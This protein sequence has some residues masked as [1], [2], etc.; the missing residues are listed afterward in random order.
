MRDDACHR[1]RRMSCEKGCESIYMHRY[2]LINDVF[3]AGIALDR[4]IRATDSC[5]TLHSSVTYRY[6]DTFDAAARSPVPNPH[7]AAVS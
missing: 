2:R 3:D 7:C 6:I 1:E 4:R 5:V